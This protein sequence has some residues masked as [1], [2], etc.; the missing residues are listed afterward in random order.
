MTFQV[1]MKTPDCLEDAIY[2]ALEDYMEEER[3]DMKAD[4]EKLCRKWFK[5]GEYLTVEI[6]TI[7]ETCR[8]V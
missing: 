1:T 4:L 8:V 3:E 5:Y 7:K 6:D 2:M